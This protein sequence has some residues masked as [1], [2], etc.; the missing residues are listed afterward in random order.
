MLEEGLLKPIGPHV[1]ELHRLQ[2]GKDVCRGA[3]DV[4]PAHVG[5]I[6]QLQAF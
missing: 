1:A 2:Q 4:D 3:H 6:G 5:H